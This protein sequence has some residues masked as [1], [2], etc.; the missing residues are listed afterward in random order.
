MKELEKAYQ[1]ENKKKYNLKAQY[2]H[3][4][5]DEIRNLDL[6]NIDVILVPEFGLSEKDNQIIIN[7]ILNEDIQVPTY[8]KELVKKVKALNKEIILIDLAPYH[9]INVLM[10]YFLK[11][12][13][14]QVKKFFQN[15]NSPRFKL[16]QELLKAKFHNLIYRRLKKIR[17]NLI[18]KKILKKLE[19]YQNKKFLILLDPA[20]FHLAKLLK[21]NLNQSL[22]EP[23]TLTKFQEIILY[24]PTDKLAILQSIVEGTIFYFLKNE[25]LNKLENNPSLIINKLKNF[26]DNLDENSI[27]EFFTDIASQPTYQDKKNWL[28][29]FLKTSNLN[30]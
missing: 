22:P 4:S 7:N 23:E 29:E 5:L 21:N 19:N 17:E 25:I 12:M 8:L 14:W 2:W 3:Q 10:E 1:P 27:N 20:N 26:V 30:I 28:I 13:S 16:N 15:F 9:L 11:E 18:F 24:R 6:T